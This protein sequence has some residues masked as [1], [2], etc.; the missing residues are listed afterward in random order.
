MLQFGRLGPPGPPGP[1]GS[2]GR[3]GDSV[4]IR[5][6]S[7][8]NAFVTNCLR[9]HPVIINLK[10]A[11]HS[12]FSTKLLHGFLHGKKLIMVSSKQ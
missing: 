1:P 10:S 6:H 9:K 5:F 8:F 4:S 12:T 2:P 11:S 7:I 3:P